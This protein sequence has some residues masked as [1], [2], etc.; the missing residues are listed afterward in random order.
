MCPVLYDVKHY[1]SLCNFY[2]TI[3][4]SASEIQIIT[5]TKTFLNK[6]QQKQCENENVIT[7]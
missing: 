6:S 3:Q 7:E 1:L 2:A 4:Y 5:K